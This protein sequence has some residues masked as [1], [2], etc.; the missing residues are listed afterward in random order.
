[1]ETNRWLKD[2]NSVR[3]DL[4]NSSNM[5]KTANSLLK[6]AENTVKS[7]RGQLATEVE[8][9]VE[10]AKSVQTANKSLM[11]QTAELGTETKLKNQYRK[12]WEKVKPFDMRGEDV[13][14]GLIFKWLL[15]KLGLWRKKK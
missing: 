11:K 6:N 1:M 4:E 13:K 15:I 12:Y 2:I 3:K 14:A 8:K 10:L 5:L 7:L 9:S